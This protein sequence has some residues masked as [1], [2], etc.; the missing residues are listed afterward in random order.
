[1]ATQRPA[2]ATVDAYIA[3]FPP[4]VQAVLQQVRQAVRAAVPVAEETISYQIPAYKQAG[5]L[6]YF[7]AFKNHIG[8]Y[9]PVS[10]DPALEAAVAPYAGEKGN[11]RFPLAEPVP[12]ELIG[13][14]TRYRLQQNLAKAAAKRP[15]K[16]RR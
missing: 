11:L 8:F 13:R 2:A 14:I 12:L 7:A 16:P 1:M 9:P 6:V 5:I 4:D 3:A 15:T 10:G